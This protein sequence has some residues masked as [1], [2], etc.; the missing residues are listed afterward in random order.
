[1]N[2]TK[3]L[4][5]LFVI[6]SSFTLALFFF[7]KKSQKPLVNY[8]TMHPS[9]ENIV[10][11]TIA[12]GSVI[13]DEEVDI[14]PNIPG[15]INKVYVR[16]G[17]VVKVGDKI[18]SISV[19]P[20]I[21]R[22]QSTKNALS[23]T[24]IDLETQQKIYNRQKILFDK[25]VISANDFDNATA[26]YNQSKQSYTSA[27]QNYE[28]A[29]TGTT[30]GFG[31]AANTIV[32]ATISGLILDVPVEEGNQVTDSNNFR[33]GTLIASIADISKM[34]FKGKIDESEVEKIKKGMSIKV[35][36]G[37]IQD[38]KF[39]AKLKY[40]SPKGFQ[41]NGTVQFDIEAQLILEENTKIRAGLSANASIILDKANDVLAI[42]ES[43]IQYDKKTKEAFVEVAIGEQ[44]FERRDIKL[45]ISDGI[46]AQVIEGVTKDDAIKIWNPINAKNK[47]GKA[48]STKK[49]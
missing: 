18:A 41:K 35:A 5:I 8:E 6:V 26:S 46:I 30:K 49:K 31:N 4:V 3:T 23:R 24:K 7:W 29:Q 44:E 9:I 40:I 10:L 28:I 22:L 14:R 12:T 43:L 47:E 36:I 25:G 19:V 2:K 33:S 37:A 42:N 17:D 45:G 39:D 34:I 15:I 1:M 48:K 13:P 11:S 21:S 38:R 32:R 20:N 16:A 27:L